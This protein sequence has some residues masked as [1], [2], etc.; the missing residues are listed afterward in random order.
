[1]ELNQ[2]S[3]RDCVKAPLLSKRP[4]MDAINLVLAL[5]LVLVLELASELELD[6]AWELE[7]GSASDSGLDLAEVGHKPEDLHN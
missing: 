1:M 7:L 3:L 2:Y 4:P 5:D 6:P